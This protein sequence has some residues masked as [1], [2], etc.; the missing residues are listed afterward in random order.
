M[1]Q[2]C[3]LASECETDQCVLSK[4][5]KTQQPKIILFIEGIKTLHK[6]LITNV[7]VDSYIVQDT[8][9]M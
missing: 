3:F 9:L 5:S 1:E 4:S 2:I 8:D 7:K 6:H